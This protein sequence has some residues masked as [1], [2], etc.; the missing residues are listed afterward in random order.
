MEMQLEMDEAIAE[1]RS[2]C[3][4]EEE[5]EGEDQE[6]KIDIFAESIRFQFGPVPISDDPL[7]PPGTPFHFSAGNGITKLDKLFKKSAI[8]TKKTLRSATSEKGKGW[9]AAA[10]S[11]FSSLRQL[12]ERVGS[13][14]PFWRR[15]SHLTR[16]EMG[17]F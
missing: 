1:W 3:G 12:D 16:L 15:G 5:D 2:S 10:L 6:V 17:V 8:S 7:T 13:D 4:Q 11:A 14:A 9:S